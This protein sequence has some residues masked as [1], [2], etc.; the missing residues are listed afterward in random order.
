MKRRI[1]ASAR[2]I[3]HSARLCASRKTNLKVDQVGVKSSSEMRS[4]TVHLQKSSGEK[5]GKD[6]R[7][8]EPRLDEKRADAADTTN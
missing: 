1:I 5:C 7:T 8:N 2:G 6:E 4:E 3:V